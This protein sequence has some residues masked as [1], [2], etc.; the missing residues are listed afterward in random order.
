MISLCQCLISAQ[1]SASQWREHLWW[2]QSHAFN[3]CF[4]SISYPCFQ[5]KCHSSTVLKRPLPLPPTHHH[6]SLDAQKGAH[7][8]FHHG[9]RQ[10]SFL[11]NLA[12]PEHPMATCLVL[13]SPCA[14]SWKNV[15]PIVM[16]W[17]G[18]WAGW[19]C[20][21][22]QIWPTPSLDWKHLKVGFCRLILCKLSCILTT[23]Y[24]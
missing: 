15:P 21:A 3:P 14:T 9:C 12:C 20:Q 2:V 1:S 10:Q 19:V 17:A 18:G 13:W 8:V 16:L 11:H 24:K 6:H 22:A 4:Q 5:S 23:I 7:I